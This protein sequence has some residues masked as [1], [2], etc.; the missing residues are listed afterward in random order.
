[1]N[2]EMQSK[3]AWIKLEKSISGILK[4]EQIKL[5]YRKEP[6]R[7][8]YPLSSL[9]ALL[10]TDDNAQTMQKRLSAFSA[11]MEGNYGHI[12]ISHEKERF[13]LEIPEKGSEYVH[14]R[15]EI[16]DIFLAEL[17]DKVR[18]HGHAVQDVF[19]VFYKYSDQVHVERTEN[20][21][22]DYLVYFEDGKPDDYRYCFHMEGDHIIY[23]RFTPEDY[24][25]FAF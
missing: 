1:M 4:E 16:Q 12:L 11:N 22:F 3:D 7:L 15:E 6:V 14:K 2:G 19:N 24:Q 18:G 25:T 10:G 20:G 8:Y 21:E 9:N 23:H 13:C 17:I 5:G